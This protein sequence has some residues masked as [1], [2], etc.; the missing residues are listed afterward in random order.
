[1]TSREIRKGERQEEEDE[2]DDYDPLDAFMA[3]IEVW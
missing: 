1:M 3:G 2:D